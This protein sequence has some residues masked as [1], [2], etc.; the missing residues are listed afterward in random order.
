MNSNKTSSKW[1]KQGLEW[2]P[3]TKTP[4][5]KN[6]T[7]SGTKKT[8]TPETKTTFQA[9]N[10]RIQDQKCTSPPQNHNNSIMIQSQKW[11]WE[12]YSERLREEPD[13]GSVAWFVVV[14]LGFSEWFV[15][16]SWGLGAFGG[17]WLEVDK[18]HCKCQGNN[19]HQFSHVITK[20][21][22][23][24]CIF[25]RKGREKWEWSKPA[26]PFTSSES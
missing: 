5:L 22:F 13:L 6:E 18:L 23:S 9:K 25:W 2:R 7:R 15:T 10:T 4:K 1:Q 16:V 8:K 20:M 12:R 21:T 24:I 17:L 26:K 19:W 3:T 14:G 11:K